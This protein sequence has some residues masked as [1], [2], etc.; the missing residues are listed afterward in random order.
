MHPIVGP[1]TATDFAA[2]VAGDRGTT[3]AQNLCP[4]G[5]MCDEG[6]ICLSFQLKVLKL[7]RFKKD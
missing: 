6:V 7:K 3:R 5:L 1:Q 4:A 2:A